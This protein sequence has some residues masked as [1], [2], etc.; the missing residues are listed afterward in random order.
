MKEKKKER[1]KEG[2]ALS[3]WEGLHRGE[4]TREQGS[5]GASQRSTKNL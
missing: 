4:T 3:L 1:E 2:G 5:S